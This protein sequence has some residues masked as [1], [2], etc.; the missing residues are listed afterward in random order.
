LKDYEAVKKHFEYSAQEFDDIYDNRGNILEKLINKVFRKGMYLRAMLALE[1]CGDNKTILDVGCGSGRI[2]VSLAKKGARVVGVDYSSQMIALANEHLR[3]CE[4]D[5]CTKVDAQFICCDFMKDFD[6]NE[7][8]DITIA[9]G[10]FDY[11]EQPIPFLRKMKNLTREK[12][13]ASYPGKFAFQTPIRKVWLYTKNCP[14]YFYS[15][16][17]LAE[18]YQLIGLSNYKIMKLPAGYLVKTLV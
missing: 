9:L 8:F 7:L 3:Q 10:V 13:I 12:I 14:V 4:K 1:E 6:S 5:S 16:K 15:E 2:S 18:M 11:V 17:K